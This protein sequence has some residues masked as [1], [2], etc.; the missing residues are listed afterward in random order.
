L[1]GFVE[2]DGYVSIEAA[3]YTKKTQPDSSAPHW[4]EIPDYGR[5]LSAMTIF[6]VTSQ[7]LLPPAPAPCLEYRMY[8]FTPG[9]VQVEAFLAPSLNFMPGR[10]ARYAI[11]FDDEAPQVIT[12]VPKGYFV[13]NGVRDWEESVKDSV[14][15]TKS[16][17]AIEQPGHHTLKFWMMDPGVVLEKLVVD[18]GG[19]KPSYLG[20][21]ESFHRE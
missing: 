21:P 4:E 20:P 11:S 17:H 9:K 2:A 7:S 12:I 3:H 18:L 19:I 15:K 10:G 8:L 14:R 16:T 1:H 6:P 13:D 5:T